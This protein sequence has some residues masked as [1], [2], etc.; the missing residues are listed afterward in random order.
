M[1]IK[2]NETYTATSLRRH[3]DVTATSQWQQAAPAPRPACGTCPCGIAKPNLTRAAAAPPRSCGSG[4]GLR[5]RSPAGGGK[6]VRGV[7]SK[8]VRRVGSGFSTV[9]TVSDDGC[10]GSSSA[11]VTAPL[12]TSSWSK[13]IDEKSS[14]RAPVAS[15]S[16]SKPVSCAS[17]A[18]G[19]PPVG[20]AMRAC[21]ASKD[22]AV[23]RV[24]RLGRS[25]IDAPRWTRT[26]RRRA[27]CGGG[28]A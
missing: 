13:P 6:R 22:P 2:I 23:A 24:R 19:A 26:P 11:T 3:C 4:S 5:P 12:S 10:D 7:S 16:T 27:T 17:V 28:V 25:E 14:Q 8:R 20:T 21:A 18:A 15:T 9:T 1:T